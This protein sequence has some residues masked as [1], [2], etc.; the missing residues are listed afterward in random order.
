MSRIIKFRAWD[1]R[2]MVS[3]QLLSLSMNGNLTFD[4]G[5][6]GVQS[7]D[8]PLMQFTGLKD[9]NGVDIYENDVVFLSKWD[10]NFVVKWDESFAGFKYESPSR[11][12]CGEPVYL[13]ETSN[14]I[15][16]GNS[17]QTPELIKGDK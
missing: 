11:G 9:K 1:G 6:V 14:V 15:V 3:H 12:E 7:L 5:S 13:D 17:F 16:I 8:Y 10:E 2:A 4:G